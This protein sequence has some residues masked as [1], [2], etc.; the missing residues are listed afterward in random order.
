MDCLT[1]VSFPSPTRRVVS[2][3]LPERAFSVVFVGP[4][5]V[6]KAQKSAQHKHTASADLKEKAGSLEAKG[7]E[8]TK[9]PRISQKNKVANS[10]AVIR[11]SMVKVVTTTGA[12]LPRMIV[13][14]HHE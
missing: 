4:E 12:A 10:P 3:G 9:D 1:L 14:H 6:G 11:G 13:S 2:L 7:T 8:V 5:S